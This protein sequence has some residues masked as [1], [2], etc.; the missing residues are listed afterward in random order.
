[1]PVPTAN[2]LQGE[3]KMKKEDAFVMAPIERGDKCIYIQE[4]IDDYYIRLSMTIDY[5]DVDGSIKEKAEKLL[6]ILNENWNK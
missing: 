5:D 1:M 6:K 4:N 2:Y 3:M